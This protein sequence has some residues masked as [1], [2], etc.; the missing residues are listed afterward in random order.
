MHPI[1]NEWQVSNLYLSRIKNYK[2][3]QIR[4]QIDDK[5]FIVILIL[6]VCRHEIHYCLYEKML[7]FNS[8]TCVCM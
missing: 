3:M 1:A 7:A 5:T 2:H 8:Y 6:Q 4:C